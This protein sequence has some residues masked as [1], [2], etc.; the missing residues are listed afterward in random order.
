VNDLKSIALFVGTGDCNAHCTHCAGLIHR[1]Y[2][3]KKDGLIDEELITQTLIDCYYKGAKHI[4]ITS[5]GEPTLSPKAVS[6]VFEIIDNYAKVG[7]VYSPINLYSNGIRIGEDKEFCDQYLPVWKD[8][9]LTHIYITVHDID[10]R[11]NAQIYGIEKYPLI[12]IILSRIHDAGLLM[13]ANMVLSK[14]SIDNLEKF[15]TTIEYLSNI[16]VDAIAAWPIRGMDDR[17]DLDA[18]PLEKELDSMERWINSQDQKNISIYRENHR[19]MYQTSQ[20]LTLFPNGTL[21]NAWCNNK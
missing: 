19:I 4:S 6:K 20:K 13:R 1:K 11:K 10:E 12:K 15:K 2:A 17:L 9:G 16:G 14:R 21:T 18:S 8:N 7:I 5:S 3:P